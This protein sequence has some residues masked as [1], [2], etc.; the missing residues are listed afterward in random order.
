MH[1][2]KGETAIDV[3]IGNRCRL[4]FVFLGGSPISNSVL[5]FDLHMQI[6]KVALTENYL[7]FWRVSNGSREKTSNRQLS[8]HQFHRNYPQYRFISCSFS[9]P[10][11]WLPSRFNSS[12]DARLASV[13]GIVPSSWFFSMYS[14]LSWLS[15]PSSGGTVP[16][17]RL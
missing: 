1:W 13:S 15:R 2:C 3:F 8:L 17:R 7:L 5:T 14:V 12:S 16:V 11:N 10:W 4:V 9:T 6:A